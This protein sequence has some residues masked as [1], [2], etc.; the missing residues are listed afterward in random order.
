[1]KNARYRPATEA[2]HAGEQIDPQSGAT[3]IGISTAVSFK[4][5]DGAKV[6]S[7]H[8]YSPEMGFN[9]VRWG[10]PTVRALE[11]RVAALEGTGDCVAFSSGMAANTAVMLD[12]L[13]AGDHAVFGN[14]CYPGVAEFAHATLAKFG[15][16]V[17]F[18]DP[19]N[20]DEVE[21]AVTKG[22]RLVFVETPAN[23]ILRL[24]DLEAIAGIAHAKGA[25][26][27]VDS[28]FATPVAT[29]PAALGADFVVHSLTKFLSG[30]GDILGGAVAGTKEKLKTLRG[31]TLIHFGQNLGAFEAW[32]AL[33]GIQT[34]FVRMER[35][36]QNALALAAFLEAHPKVERVLYPGLSSHP[37]HEL[38]KRQMRNFGGVL[39]FRLK[40]G[41]KA[42]NAALA[43]CRLIT[44]AVSL[45]KSKSLIY[46]IAT[47][48]L[49]KNSFRLSPEH[50]K[51][52]RGW[53]GE[54]VIRFSVGLEDVEDLIEEIDRVLG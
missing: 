48:E 26:L 5:K 12:R 45:G 53:A 35:H 11:D 14:V 16:K 20:L 22:T 29:N 15:V 4:P 32:L 2:L 36:E 19:S 10:S 42:A 21:A 7:A 31:E 39:S 52:Y 13:K 49:Q 50:L 34:L 33:R 24:C 41:E 6:F 1:M 25:E 54:G 46:S 43:K 47:A 3:S 23:P 38:A 28:T 40:G 37:Q 8:E 9:Y 51:D 44:N 17:T 30:H 18:V 27:A